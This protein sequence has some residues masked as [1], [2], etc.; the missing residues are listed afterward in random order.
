MSEE[1]QTTLRTVF[2]ELFSIQSRLRRIGLS[3]VILVV[4]IVPGPIVGK[5]RQHGPVPEPSEGQAF[6]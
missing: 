5:P 3:S 2:E 1:N 6:F 4:I